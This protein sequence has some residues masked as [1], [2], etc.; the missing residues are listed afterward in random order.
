ME[1]PWTSRTKSQARHGQASPC[2]AV[3]HLDVAF[4]FEHIRL[5]NDHLSNLLHY[6]PLAYYCCCA[7]VVGDRQVVLPYSEGDMLEDSTAKPYHSD[8][9]LG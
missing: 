3:D 5:V 8:V 2:H 4:Q 9:E 1:M 6:H 7:F